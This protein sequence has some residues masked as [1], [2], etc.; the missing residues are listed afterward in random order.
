MKEQKQTPPSQPIEEGMY[1]KE[2]MEKLI[3]LRKADYQNEL[4]SVGRKIMHNRAELKEYWTG[5]ID[6]CD[7]ILTSLPKSKE[8]GVQ[9]FSREDMEKFSEFL[10][11]NWIAEPLFVF[12]NKSAKWLVDRFITSLPQSTGV[13]AGEEIVFNKS[14]WDNFKLR[15]GDR[16]YQGLIN[17]EDFATIIGELEDKSIK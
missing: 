2:Q 7:D 10:F 9:L 16:N 11:Q 15:M 4:S 6:A 12:K 14:D 8:Q 1:T 3:T 13:S 5:R 17:I